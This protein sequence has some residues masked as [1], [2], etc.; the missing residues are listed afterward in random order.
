MCY[1]D[2]ERE[3]NTVVAFVV[4]LIIGGL[5]VWVFSDAP[6][7]V[8][9]VEVVN[10][11]CLSEIHPLGENFVIT[12]NKAGEYEYQVIMTTRGIEVWKEC[13]V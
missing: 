4:G 12:E 8:E 9:K 6:V 1:R 2:G 3:Q 7:E 10:G 13:G 5:L 11:Y